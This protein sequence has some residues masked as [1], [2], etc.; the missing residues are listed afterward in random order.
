LHYTEAREIFC[1]AWESVRATNNPALDLIAKFKNIQIAT[2]NWAK[3]KFNGYNKG[4][5]RAK[6]IIQILDRAEARLL[7]GPELRL[8][9]ALK[10]HTYLLANI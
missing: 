7:S 10:E 2:N 3:N 5:Q 9:I 6:Y 1:N 4:I 8:R